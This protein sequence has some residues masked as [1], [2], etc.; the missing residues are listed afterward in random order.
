VS[1]QTGMRF[2]VGIPAAASTHEFEKYGP[3]SSGFD[4]ADYVP[5]ALAALEPLEGHG[6][7]LGHMI[8]ALTHT[9]V[10][11][12]HSDNVM[13]PTTASAEPKVWALLQGAPLP[14][15][16]PLSPRLPPPPSPPPAPATTARSP[17]PPTPPPSPGAGGYARDGCVTS[18]DCTQIVGA[19]S[20]CRGDSKDECGRSV[21]QGDSHSS[22]QPCPQ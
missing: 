14:P 4:Q 5:H 2:M 11:P 3:T 19:P 15:G 10:Y 13:R 1:A 9:N 17:P 12:P 7:Y 6:P 20:F 16:T 8:W 21:C 18:T 22:L